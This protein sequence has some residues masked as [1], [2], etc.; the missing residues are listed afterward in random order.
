MVERAR[1]GT[2]RGRWLTSIGVAA[3]YC[4]AGWVG[5]LLAIPPGYATAVWPAAGI[6]VAAVLMHGIGVWPGVFL[7]ALLVNLSLLLPSDAP[8]A[9]GVATALAIAGGATLGALASA[10]LAH[11][12]AAFPNALASK[13]EVVRFLFYAGLLGS[14]V[15]AAIGPMA[16]FLSGAV[17]G[18]A[19]GL[20]M[21]IWW[22]GDSLGVVLFAPLVLAWRGWPA[23]AG[24]PERRSAIAV[25]AAAM[26]GLTLVMVSYTVAWERDRLA[27]ALDRHAHALAEA[28]GRQAGSGH[29]D[30]FVTALRAQPPAGLDWWL[31]DVSAEGTRSVTAAAAGASGWPQ[32]PRREHLGLFAGAPALEWHDEQWRGERLLRLVIGPRPEFLAAHRPAKAWLLLLGGLVL[33]SL[34]GAMTMVLT[35]RDQTLRRLVEARTRDAELAQ[36][37]S[38]AELRAIIDNSPAVIFVKDAEGRYLL[39]NRQYEKL[40]DVTR[41]ELCGRT[42]FDVFPPEFA[43]PIRA[44]DAAVL[45][46]NA[47][48][49][50]DEIVPQA[51]GPHTY[52]SVKFPFHD[53]TGRPIAVCGIATDIT[54]RQRAEEALRAERNF[55]TAVIN[56]LPGVFYLIAKEGHFDKW[57]WNFE[58]VSGYSAEEIAGMSPLDFFDDDDKKAVS[59]KIEDVF[60][61]GSATIEAM[62][63]T[64]SGR[65][66]PYYFSGQRL[67][68]PSGDKLIGTG[69]D[70]SERK[71]IEERLRTSNSELEAFAYVAS[72]DLRQ[73]L[74]IV[75]SYLQILEQHL[76]DVLDDEAQTYMA[77]ASDA[78]RRMDGLIVDLLEYSRVGRMAEPMRRIDMRAVIADALDILGVATA[79]ADATIEVDAGEWPAVLADAGEMVRL[80][81]N[82]IGNAIKYRQPDVAPHIR[83]S[84]APSGA[85]WTFM[86][87]DNG[88]GMKPDYFERIFGVFQR[89]HAQGT[90]EG[91]G[92]GLAICRKIVTRHGGRIWVESDGPNTGCRFRFTI[93]MATDGAPPGE[94]S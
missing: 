4:G 64:K 60:R 73:P 87:A 23:Q 88:I 18:D 57:N 63:L 74:R 50:F 80:M 5:L 46:A 28:A 69:L 6:A 71:A 2:E 12:F 24:W 77:F 83:V 47:P 85:Q 53:Q 68:L 61:D 81:Q 26:F 37:R 30:A 9:A 75:R 38:E 91:T 92:I 79:E 56:S 58:T 31:L 39:V 52:L 19:L 45:V 15:S 17:P 3:A 42:D 22:S 70:I 44:N 10:A 32:P 33:T 66:T 82:L 49:E 48:V 1:Q 59:A 62:F 40:F 21:A 90:Y 51:D 76:G 20:R 41:E 94:E 14:G 16:L 78:A 36:R 13:R 27:L 54:V 93:P 89:L 65:R 29:A 34:T 55:S 35:G 43:H 67:S 11:R 25:P 72:H 86:V 8:V 84:F 7:G